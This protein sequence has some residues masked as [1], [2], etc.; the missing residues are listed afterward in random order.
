M[1]GETAPELHQHIHRGK[2]LKIIQPS[3]E[4][5]SITDAASL[6]IEKAARVCYKSEDMAGP[7][8]DERLIRSCM[9]KHH[10]SIIEHG[11]ASFRIICDRGIS[12]EIVRHRIASYSQESTRYCNYGK[13]KFGKEISVV[14]PPG[15]SGDSEGAW[16][17]AM[18]AS[19]AA[20]FQLLE[21]GRSPQI[22]RSVLPTCLKTE[23]IMTAN[24][25]EWRHFVDLRE[26]KTAHPQIR[27]LAARVRE[28]LVENCP[29]VFGDLKAV[30]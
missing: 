25:R 8:T 24:F 29:A 4:L 18:V 26:A 16:E 12:H 7:G 20:Y 21:A 1:G 28:F 14:R 6:L 10:M 13:D 2:N 9:N 15:L 30:E 23:L 11:V 17:R 19:E 22:A 3:V 27:P 5:L